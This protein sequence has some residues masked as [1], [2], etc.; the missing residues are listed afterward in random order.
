MKTGFLT[1]IATTTFLTAILAVSGMPAAAQMAPRLIIAPP[2]N[3]ILNSGAPPPEVMKKL[4][5]LARA[6]KE[7][8]L[9]PYDYVMMAMAVW[10]DVESRPELLAEGLDTL[11][12]LHE[13]CTGSAQRWQIANKAFLIARP[14]QPE[15]RREALLKMQEK[16][17]DEGV[18][19]YI[20]DLVSK[21]GGQPA[22]SPSR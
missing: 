18:K 1:G 14:A 2:I 19:Q 15:L 16:E 3:E 12:V 17:T 11:A 8:S 21:I 6:G 13:F 4:S 20:A 10:E 9:Q 7:K 22:P 5:E